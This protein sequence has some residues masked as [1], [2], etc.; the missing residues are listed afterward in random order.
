MSSVSSLLQA[1]GLAREALLGLGQGC[2]LALVRVGKEALRMGGLASNMMT[3]RLNT[4]CL[5]R[6]TSRR[7]PSKFARISGGQYAL[8][9]H[10]YTPEKPARAGAEAQHELKVM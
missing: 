6:S 1:A 2:M 8:V 5:V 10:E 7:S 3:P 9:P 4:S